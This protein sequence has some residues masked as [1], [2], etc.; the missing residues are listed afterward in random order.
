MATATIGS[1]QEFQPGAEPIMAYL[2]RLKAFLDANGIA[3][4]NRAAVLIS[5]IGLKTYAVL[6]SLIAPDTPQSKSYADLVQALKTHYH[7]KRLIIAERYMFNQRSQHPGESIAD[8]VAELRRLASTCNFVDFLDDALRDRLVCGLVNES[9][10]RRLLADADGTTTFARVTE[11]AQGFEQ[12]EKNAKAVKTTEA[13][14]KKLSVTPS[15]PHTDRPVNKSHAT[16]VAKLTT[17]LASVVGPM[18][19][20]TI[21]RKRGT[22]PQHAARRKVHMPHNDRQTPSMLR[23]RLMTVTPKNFACIRSKRKR[24]SLLCS[25]CRSKANHFRW[26]WTQ[27]RLTP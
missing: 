6:R 12:A 4:D 13:S 23:Q 21:A 7:P 3:N 1:M 27:E 2:E 8:Y 17:T 19:L 16:D 18:P 26:S 9:S 25:P 20:A 24:P 10:H 11:L 22:L 15:R 14:L 5:T